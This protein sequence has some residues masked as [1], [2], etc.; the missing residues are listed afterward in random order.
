MTEISLHLV[1]HER[2]ENKR[3]QINKHWKVSDFNSFPFPV[4]AMI[5]KELKEMMKEIEVDLKNDNS[6]HATLTPNMDA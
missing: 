1:I 2:P 4:K 3:L 5:H 6:N